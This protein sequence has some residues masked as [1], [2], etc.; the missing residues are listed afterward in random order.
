MRT[1]ITEHQF[2]ENFLSSN[3]GFF[4]DNFLKA[5]ASR[6]ISVLK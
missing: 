4:K 3:M 5:D 1:K 2:A 6:D